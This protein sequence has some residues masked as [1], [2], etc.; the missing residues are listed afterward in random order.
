MIHINENSIK[1]KGRT[2]NEI[3]STIKQNKNKNESTRNTFLPNPCKIYRH[4]LPTPFSNVSNSGNERTSLHIDNKP[5]YTNRVLIDNNIIDCNN[6][7]IQKPINDPD[8]TPLNDDV[9][10]GNSIKRVRS[11]GMNP[12]KP[13]FISNTKIGTKYY[14]NKQQYIDS[15]INNKCIIYNPNNQQFSQQGAVSYSNYILRKS[16]DVNRINN[17]ITSAT[18]MLPLAYAQTIKQN[19]GNMANCQ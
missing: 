9:I 17:E 2:Y 16:Y 11:S 14:T 13:V 7:I 5:G 10:I 8:K 19:I 4:E 15:T 1:W 18:Y 6:I 12:E 3:V